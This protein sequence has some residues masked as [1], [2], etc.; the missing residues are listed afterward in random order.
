MDPSTWRFVTFVVV[1]G[2]I[3]C[4]SCLCAF[5][6]LRNMH[7][8][9]WTAYKVHSSCGTVTCSNQ[10][11]LFASFPCTA[12]IPHPPPVMTEPHPMTK[13]R[14]TGSPHNERKCLLRIL[15]HVNSCEFEFGGYGSRVMLS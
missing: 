7:V 8:L 11:A 6:T 13:Q 1:G 14:P 5:V 9:Y 4:T 15:P 3:V 10:F 2:N 12:S